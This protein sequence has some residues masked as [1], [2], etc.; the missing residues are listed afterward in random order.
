MKIICAVLASG[1]AFS[2]MAF[3]NPPAT[4][5]APPGV[6]SSDP[7]LWLETSH[8]PRALEWV[9][10]QNAITKK[11]F[12]ESPEFNKARGEILEVLDSEAR[13]PY[14]HRMGGYLYNF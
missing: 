1:I 8:G 13:I 5:G 11:R 14:V 3:A 10:A 9:E 2:G 6:S 12:M 4:S 7:Y